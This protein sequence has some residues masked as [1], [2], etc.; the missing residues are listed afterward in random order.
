MVRTGADSQNITD[1]DDVLTNGEKAFCEYSFK[2][3]N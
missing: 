3:N 1:H 2:T